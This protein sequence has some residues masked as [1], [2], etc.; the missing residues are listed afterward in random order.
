MEDVSGGVLVRAEG[1][2]SELV[3]GS[4][5]NTDV[6]RVIRATLFGGTPTGE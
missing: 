4:F 2:N 5:D 1:L 6:A 3:H